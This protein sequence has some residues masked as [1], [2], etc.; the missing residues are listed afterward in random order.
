MVR[1]YVSFFLPMFFLL[2]RRSRKS[3][4]SAIPFSELHCDM[5][6]KIK[7]KQNKIPWG[8]VPL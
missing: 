3:R 6:N 2:S 7:E 5:K 8:L 4:R 1:K